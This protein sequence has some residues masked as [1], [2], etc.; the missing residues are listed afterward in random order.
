RGPERKH[1]PWKPLNTTFALKTRTKAWVRMWVEERWCSGTLITGREGWEWTR[2][3]SL[4]RW[5][6]N[7]DVEIADF[8]PGDQIIV[9]Y[10]NTD[11]D[12]FGVRVQP[13]PENPARPF[14]CV[15]DV[16]GNGE[17]REAAGSPVYPVVLSGP[18]EQVIAI[19]PSLVKHGETF[20]VRAS[21]M[22]R[23]LTH[24]NKRYEG[25]MQF[26]SEADALH[27]PGAEPSQEGDARALANV[28]AAK[29]GIGSIRV[30][31][32]VGAAE[33]NPVLV[34]AEKQENLYWGDLHAQ[35]MY[36][37][38]HSDE[39][40][41]AS[42]LTPAE[43]CQYAKECSLLDFVAMA[44]SGCPNPDN[45]GWMESQQATIDAYEPG[46]F[47]S[48]KAWEC[49]LGVQGDRT[50]V[51]R[52]AE[53]EPNFVIP[54]KDAHSPTNAHALLRFCRESKYR[55][56]TSNHSFMKYLDWSVFDPAIDRIVEVYSCWGSY[57]SREDNPLNSKRRPKNQ[58]L[59]HMLSLGYTPGIVAAG[60]S[61]VG[62]PGRSLMYADPLWCQCWKAGLA[63]VYSPELTREAIW[64]ALYH[65]HCYGTTGV[66]IVLRF[67]LN[68]ARMG[69]ILE[70]GKNDDRLCRRELR[71]TVV[72]TDYIRRVDIIKNNGVL[73]RVCPKTDRAEFSF[74]DQL[75][76][77][78]TTRDWYYV[79]V[80]Q[81][82]G[83]AAWS[84]PIWVGPEGVS[85]PSAS[86]GE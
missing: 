73:H 43:M 37:V 82:D 19:A 13:F 38:W 6:I 34:S 78:P 17:L 63:A 42:T 64:D 58:S 46:R 4:W 35:C 50:L 76:A 71:V 69:S 44:N 31:T 83:N 66:R 25:P 62:Y 2:Y 51:Y 11:E 79:R 41:G 67:H 49:G 70:Y 14:V 28:K 26:A 24:P 22:D 36:H 65:R 18:P 77:P 81:A 20:T 47:V 3:A 29:P 40:R 54:R 33:T 39:G 68:G 61:H 21:V 59:M 60:D 30:T 1:N 12:P 32:S 45:P 48:F 75:D 74:T 9:T 55:I 5:W 84:S 56:I 23:N 53:V 10:G 7:A 15:V 8:E 52:E 86:L 85:A 16:D 27:V 57:E 72:G 80:F